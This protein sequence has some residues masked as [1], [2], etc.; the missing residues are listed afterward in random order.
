[1]GYST[2]SFAGGLLGEHVG[3]A[4]AFEVAAACLTAAAAILVV[5]R[6]I[7]HRTILRAAAPGPIGLGAA[8]P[9]AS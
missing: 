1:M 3:P 8:G 5:Q 2:G 6:V 4:Q 9:R 7:A